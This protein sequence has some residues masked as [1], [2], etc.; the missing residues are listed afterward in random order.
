MLVRPHQIGSARGGIEALRKN[1]GFVE[2]IL[3][4]RCDLDAVNALDGGAFA[5]IEQL[6]FAAKLLEQKARLAR[7]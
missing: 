6:E 5:E 2:K 4:D 7:S 1:T 3:P